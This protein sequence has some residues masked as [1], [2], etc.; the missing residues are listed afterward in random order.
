MC[1]LGQFTQQLKPG[2]QILQK[3]DP[4]DTECL[5][6][7]LSRKVHNNIVNT[8]LSTLAININD[9]N[10]TTIETKVKK[11][12]SLFRKRGVKIIFK[13]MKNAKKSNL[14]KRKGT[15]S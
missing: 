6:P 15:V 10:R 11:L 4:S 13:P 7:F 14:S 5:I 8:K 3:S 9:D 1:C 2:T 12:K